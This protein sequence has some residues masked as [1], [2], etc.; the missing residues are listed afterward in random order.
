MKE[1]LFPRQLSVCAIRNM[2][3]Y[4]PG[5]TLGFGAKLF[6][7][8][9]LFFCCICPIICSF[10]PTV[11]CWHLTFLIKRVTNMATQISQRIHV[12]HVSW[13]VRFDQQ[14]ADCLKVTCFMPKI[15]NGTTLS[16]VYR[17]W[18]FFHKSWLKMFVCYLC[19]LF[20]RLMRRVVLWRSTLLSALFRI[21]R[22]NY[23]MLK[24]P[25]WKDNSNRYQE[26]R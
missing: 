17:Q 10:Q 14:K 19:V 16:K 7:V 22:V 1:T 21:S 11:V 20:H 15:K 26:N 6:A 13:I 5:Q 9:Y 23:K 12:A 4:R 2:D 3:K 24:W 18:S 25:H 8:F